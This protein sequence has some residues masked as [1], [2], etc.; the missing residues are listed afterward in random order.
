MKHVKYF[1]GVVKYFDGVPMKLVQPKGRVRTL[2]TDRPSLKVG[3]G[4][5]VQVGMLEF[6]SEYAAKRFIKMLGC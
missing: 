6:H 5:T 4:C 2:G 3:H 1:K